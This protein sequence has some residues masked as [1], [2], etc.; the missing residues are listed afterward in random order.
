VVSAP[1]YHPAKLGEKVA[2]DELVVFRSEQVLP[3]YIVYYRR[4]VQIRQTLFTCQVS[5]APPAGELELEA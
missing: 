2:A 3:R 1:N 5:K 4:S